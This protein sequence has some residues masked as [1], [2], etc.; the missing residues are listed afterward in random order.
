MHIDFP[1]ILV[2][3]TL[4][5]G[6]V[7]GLDYFYLRKKRKEAV[8]GEE[9]QEPM[10]IEMSRG[11]FP[12]FLVVLVL[13]SFVI[14]PFRIPSGSMMPTLLIGDFILV[15]KYAYGL[16]LPVLE[17]KVVDLGTPKRGDVVVFRYPVNPRLDYIKRVIGVPGDVVDYRNKTLYINGKPQVQTPV[18]RFQ[19]SGSNN[20]VGFMTATEQL[21]NVEHKTM[22][23]PLAPDF[24][25][26]CRVLAQGPVTVPEGSYFVMGDNRDNSYDGRCWG[27]VPDSNLRGRAIGIWMNW[28]WNRSGV[29]DWGRIGMGIN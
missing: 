17:T 13:R 15:N 20:L 4:A 19:G 29:V 12:V 16:R 1:T 28:D 11:F 14:E 9:P 5:T 23:H 10:L 7:W 6:A 2:L 3:L 22:I 8:S 27:M 26:D 25:P 18:G 24:G 21:G